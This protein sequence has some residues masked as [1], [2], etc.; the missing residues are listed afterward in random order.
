MLYFAVIPKHLCGCVGV[1]VRRYFY[2]AYSSFDENFYRVKWFWF[3][4]NL[5]VWCNQTN[6]ENGSIVQIEIRNNRRQKRA[7]VHCRDNL[8][9]SFL[10][11]LAFYQMFPANSLSCWCIFY[12]RSFWKFNILSWLAN[13]T[14]LIQI[15]EYVGLFF[16]ILLQKICLTYNSR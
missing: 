13:E 10:P 3:N 9:S 1:I 8:Q 14:I 12:K 15:V 7:Q 6:Q 16:V 11:F 2:Y 5:N 4:E